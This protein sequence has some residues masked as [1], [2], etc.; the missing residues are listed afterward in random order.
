M[1][2]ESPSTPS[3]T[4]AEVPTTKTARFPFYAL[5]F[6]VAGMVLLAVVGTIEAVALKNVPWRDSVILLTEE[7]P[8]DH[9]IEAK[10][11]P[12]DTS[13]L[14]ANPAMELARADAAIQSTLKQFG[15]DQPKREHV[16]TVSL[17]EEAWQELLASGRLPTPGSPEVLAGQ[18]TR[19]DRFTLGGTIFHVVGRIREEAPAFTFCYALPADPAFD[20]LFAS[21]DS[22]SG[23]LYRDGLHRDSNRIMAAAKEG[24]STELL[25]GYGRIPALWTVAAIV[26]LIVVTLGGMLFVVQGLFWW[27]PHSPALIRPVLTELHLRSGL[28]LGLHVLGYGAW[29]L[30]MFLALAYPRLNYFL[31]SIVARLFVSGDLQHVGAAYASESILHAA[32]A[33]FYQN[34]VTATLVGTILVSLVI[35]FWGVFKNLLSFSVLG[36]AMAPLWA[37]STMRYVYHSI[38]IVLE[39]EAYTLA[40]FII[41]VWPLRWARGV[42]RGELGREVTTGFK[43]LLSGTAVVAA[44]LVLAA[45][46][47]ATTIILLK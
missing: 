23:W 33:T 40:S 32:Y 26:G 7:A 45:L 8:A 13:N 1:S 46:Y 41:C 21:D 25:G 2:D 47:E 11:R 42:F 17:Q 24:K 27:E 39:L 43:V 29:F 19:F 16:V 28:Y 4:M 22:R 36:F 15:L 3:E 5:A 38:T 34:F 6:V 9:G 35:P 30:F 18:L 14:P 31:I 44:I 12:I 37:D 10:V 20:A